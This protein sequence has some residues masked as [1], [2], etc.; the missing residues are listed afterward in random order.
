[1][2]VDNV[3]VMAEKKEPLAGLFIYVFETVF[4][5]GV[6]LC[7]NTCLPRNMLESVPA[8]TDEPYLQSPQFFARNQ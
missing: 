6:A 7:S 8:R 4:S 1:M 3:V 5:T 2:M